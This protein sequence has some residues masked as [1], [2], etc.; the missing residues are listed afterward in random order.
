M[1]KVLNGPFIQAG[2][3]LSDGIDCSEGQLVRI[4]MPPTW[5]GED[6]ITFQFSTDG[7]FYNEMYGIDGYAVSIKTVVPGAGVIIPGEIGKAIAWLKIRSG[8]EGNP[9]TQEETRNFAVTVLVQDE[10]AAPPARSAKKKAPAK[11]KA[12]KKKSRR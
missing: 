4:T 2:E 5:G 7:L 12:A 10:A 3:S 1:L 6:G 9:V 11:K 8:T